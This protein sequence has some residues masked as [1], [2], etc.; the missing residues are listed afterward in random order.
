MK[1]ENMKVA[2]RLLMEKV[3]SSPTPRWMFWS[4]Q[5]SELTPLKLEEMDFPKKVQGKSTRLLYRNVR[6]EF[7]AAWDNVKSLGLPRLRTPRVRQGSG[8]SGRPHLLLECLTRL[9]EV[10]ALN[11]QSALRTLWHARHST[12]V[13]G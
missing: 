13:H 12:P 9:P 5:E 1:C 3:F 7:L 8:E 11:G 10:L 4:K 6:I 2:E